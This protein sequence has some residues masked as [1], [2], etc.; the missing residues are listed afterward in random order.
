MRIAYLVASA[1][2]V[3]IGELAAAVRDRLREQLPEY[4]VPD[5]WVVL[6]AFPLNANSKVD[7]RR[8]QRGSQ[9]GGD[10]SALATM[11]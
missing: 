7:G 10:R 5:Q 11:R 2:T 6:E 1:T 3:E 9:R 8:A 4:M